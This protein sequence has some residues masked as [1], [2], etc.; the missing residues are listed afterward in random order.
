MNE[1]NMSN[2]RITRRSFVAGVGGT[3][4]ALAVSRALAA[5][6]EDAYAMV[7]KVDRARILP[8]SR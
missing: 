4:G 6:A 3:A 5:P 2:G 1:K 8:R 7:A